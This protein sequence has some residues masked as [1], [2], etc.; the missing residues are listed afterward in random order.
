[1]RYTIF[2]L[3]VRKFYS[4][5][6]T[7][8]QGFLLISFLGI[9]MA[10]TNSFSAEIKGSIDTFTP[11]NIGRQFGY[12]AVHPDG[13][14]LI[15]IEYQGG[16][17]TKNYRSDIF[18]YNIETKSY[19]RFELPEGYLYSS[20]S[21]SPKG[22]YILLTRVPIFKNY[23]AKLRAFPENEQIKAFSQTQILMLGVRGNSLKIL[24]IPMGR[25]DHPIMS[26]D[27][28]KILYALI[29][30]SPKE[31]FV[32]D[33]SQN[34]FWEFDLKTSRNYL[35]AGPFGFISAYP[36]QY[37]NDNEILISSMGYPDLDV[38]KY[39]KEYNSSKIMEL[40][41][42]STSRPFPK[43]K[44]VTEGISD[45]SIDKYDNYY[46]V[47]Y[48]YTQTGNNIFKVTLEGGKIV[49]PI[50]ENLRQSQLHNVIV[51]RDGKKIFFLYHAAGFQ[52]QE[53]KTAIG[54]FD[55]ENSQ[56]ST[57]AIPTLNQVH[58]NSINN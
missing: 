4:S 53:W 19:K 30:P 29:T 27:E 44:E 28:D 14:E 2:K 48:Q 13:K 31:R 16:A 43:Y 50:P 55:I 6:L 36:H 34:E 5:M 25:L 49:Y 11:T 9:L 18:E 38:F 56:W 57:V 17:D 12:L 26:P 37:I 54:Q 22:N 40:S 8:M 24:P 46:L 35:F 23:D 32:G 39:N 15:F 10:M 21:F 41:R 51:T 33:W 45:A 42:S 7:P 20:P 1:M 3:L 47:G 58:Q 52:I